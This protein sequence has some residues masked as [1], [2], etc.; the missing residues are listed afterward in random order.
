MFIAAPEHRYIKMERQSHDY[1]NIWLHTDPAINTSSYIKI[2]EQLV[3]ENDS[4]IHLE[5][6]LFKFYTIKMIQETDS[7]VNF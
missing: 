4:S 2:V 7:G 6:C 1:K 5:F 3:Q